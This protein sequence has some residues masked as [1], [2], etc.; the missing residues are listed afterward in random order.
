M[1]YA[2]NDR[3]HFAECNAPGSPE[4]A[5]A[6]SEAE[7]FMKYRIKYFGRV[8]LEAELHAAYLIDARTGE[9][10]TPRRE[11]SREK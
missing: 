10:I 2:E 5:E 3:R 7:Q 6:L 1:Y 11:H 4:R 9:R 8:K